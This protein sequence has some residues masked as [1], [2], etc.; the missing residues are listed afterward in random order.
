[1]EGG[2]PEAGE[3]VEVRLHERIAE[4]PEA[5]WDALLEPDSSPFVE[6]GWLDALER[7]GCVVPDRGWLP[8]HIGVYRAGTLIA[9]APAYV[10][11]NSE[12]E[13]VFDHQWAGVAHRLG[14]DYYP[15]L[16]LAVPFTPATGDRVL[17]KAGEDR[18]VLRAVIADAARAIADQ[19][20]LSSAHLLFPREDEAKAFEGRKWG[21]RLGIQFHWKNHGYATYDD[22]LAR[23][24][25]KRRHQ[26]KRERRMVAEQ[27]ITIETRRGE[28]FDEKTVALAYKYYLSTVDKFVWGR[29]YLNEKFFQLVVERFAGKRD[30]LVNP[31]RCAVELVV[32]SKNGRPVGGA[33]NVAK[34]KRLYGRYWGAG[35][36]HPF[37]HFAVCFYH[38]ID[39]CIARGFEAFEPGAGGEHKVRRGFDPT[40]T[41]SA[42]FIRDPRLDR[43]IRDFLPRERAH[44]E[45]ILRGEIGEDEAG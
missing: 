38:S 30:D 28:A 2:V 43:I 11:G 44:V 24:D 45:R 31:R 9:A 19:L 41:H 17:I 25:S 1:M 10:K 12:G 23:F 5:S 27:G 16:I 6:W 20:G 33:F 22:F 32:A 13:F 39:E 15:K 36:E 26:L 42:H 3:R 4:I 14:V 34:G 18:A 7:A 8:R 21:A 40:A 29:R 37:L 35:S